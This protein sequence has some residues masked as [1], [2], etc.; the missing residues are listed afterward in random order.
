MQLI[1]RN[2][3]S[4][5]CSHAH[6]L[7]SWHWPGLV[8]THAAPVAVGG[9]NPTELCDW[10]LRGIMG[11]VYHLPGRNN[12]QF[13]VCLSNESFWSQGCT[14]RI[15]NT[16]Y[17][18][19]SPLLFHLTSKLTNANSAGN[20]VYFLFCAIGWV[21]LCGQSLCGHNWWW[22]IFSASYF[23]WGNSGQQVSRAYLRWARESI[24]WCI[25]PT[26]SEVDF[27]LVSIWFWTLA[28]WQAL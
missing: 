1:E 19:L 28:C 18:L 22:Y 9:E 12:W 5:S 20:L 24:R 6:C 2:K 11:G 23:H 13:L 16:K 26:V 15:G 10:C 21:A 7:L 17:G 27:V 4:C 3:I 8:V 25:F 14:L